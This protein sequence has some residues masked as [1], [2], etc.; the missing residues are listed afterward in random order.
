MPSQVRAA[1][2]GVNDT[3]FGSRNWDNP[4]SITQEGLSNGYAYGREGTSRYLKTSSHGFSIPANSTI[5]GIQARIKRG[6]TEAL[7]SQTAKDLRVRLVKGGAVQSAEDK[8]DTVTNWGYNSPSFKTY[9]G[10]TDLWS[11]TW[12]VA[13]INA[14]N[15]GLVLAAEMDDTDSFV[16]YIELTVWY[17][18]ALP[19]QSP[20]SPP[21]PGAGQTRVIATAGAGAND[22]GSGTVAWTNAE[23]VTAEDQVNATTSSALN[24][25][26]SQNLTTGTHGFN[27]PSNASVDGIWA[28]VRRRPSGSG[29][30]QDNSV[31]LKKTSGFTASN[32]ASA[33]NW[34]GA[35]ADGVYGGISDKWG[36]TWTHTDINHND[37]GFVFQ[38][39]EVASLA[40]SPQVDVVQ[41]AVYYTLIDAPPPPPEDEEEEE[42]EIGAFGE[43]VVI[44]EDN[45]NVL[46]QAQAQPEISIGVAPEG[47]A[48]AYT[49]N[50][51]T[52]T[53][54]YKKVATQTEITLTATY[55]LPDAEP[56]EFEW[57]FGDGIKGYGNPVTHTWIVANKNA[58]LALRI[59]D[60]KR[61]VHTTSRQLYLEE[62]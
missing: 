1:G 54:D 42:G 60:S 36:T 7:S 17:S 40:T 46:P 39:K 15:F 43:L 28:R 2:T 62:A 37:F 16:D 32:R 47:D 10:S 14:S 33:S 57:F 20:I 24:N 27:L 26:S 38:A 23:N 52:Y 45:I 3:S 5:D 59:T 41:I 4:H 22:A 49:V 21:A 48:V 34:Y 31:L 50:G 6:K 55:T 44:K 30:L 58:K 8:A 53:S 35:Y 13:D 61:R 56:L 51:T 29:T 18:E 9:G 19:D 25:S 11:N 12:T